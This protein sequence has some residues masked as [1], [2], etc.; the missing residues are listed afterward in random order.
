LPPLSE[1]GGGEESR[2][3]LTDFYGVE[4]IVMSEEKKNRTRI[5]GLR[6]TIG[7]YED[8]ETKVAKKQLP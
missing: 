6:L 3:L 7:E 4:D 2:L 5:I 8:L 1:V